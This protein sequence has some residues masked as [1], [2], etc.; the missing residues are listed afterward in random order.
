MECA[1]NVGVFSSFLAEIEKN[2]IH[3]TMY[4]TTCSV[5]HNNN[6]IMIGMIR[7]EIV[8]QPSRLKLRS[9]AH[10]LVFNEIADSLNK[11]NQ[12]A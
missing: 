6:I 2:G 3:G 8:P 10:W 11:K 1:S 12:K 9:R 4:C 5:M 7:I